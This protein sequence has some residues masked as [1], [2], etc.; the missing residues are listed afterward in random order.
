MSKGRRLARLVGSWAPAALLMATIWVLSSLSLT[1]ISIADLPLRDKGAHFLAYGALGFWVAHAVRAT[2]LGKKSGRRKALKTL[3]LAWAITFGW[4]LLDELHQAYVPG[5]SPELLD[6]VADAIGAS[7]GAK[8]RYLL[9]FSRWG[10]KMD[11]EVVPHS[12]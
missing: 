10:Q 12:S 11:S 5:R 2:W 1:G 4:G 7:F 9:A 6:L 8:V 3:V